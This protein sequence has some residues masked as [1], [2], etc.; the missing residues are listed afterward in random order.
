MRY[1]IG[2]CLIA[3]GGP[4]TALFGPLFAP[5][6]GAGLILFLT[7]PSLENF[8]DYVIP[9]TGEVL[10][11]RRHYW[12]FI[13]FTIVSYVLTLGKA[14]L[15]IPWKE[16]YFK[17]TLSEQGE[18]VWTPVSRR[19]YKALRNQM[20]LLYSGQTLSKQFILDTYSPETIAYR[21]K[22]ARLIAASILAG[23]CV[24]MLLFP[25][26]FLVTLL[27]GPIFIP[28]ALLWIPDF[29]DARIL[30]TAY[31]QAQTPDT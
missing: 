20:R 22:K 10:F 17:V 23:I 24:A 5:L 14:S 12:H 6:M 29:R 11:R 27:Y 15:V 28:M 3:V 13:P 30:Q 2:F 19:E 26:G 8:A 18:K 9:D 21:R 31:N 4:L 16:R 25:M 7:F 1:I